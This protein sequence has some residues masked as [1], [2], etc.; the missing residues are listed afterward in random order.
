M[1]RRRPQREY[2]R[3]LDGEQE[4][5]LTTIPLA[6]VGYLAFDNG[7]RGWIPREI[8]VEHQVDAGSSPL[9]P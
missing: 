6:V 9:V 3:K 5:H 2:R 1:Q 8:Q 7:R 4:A